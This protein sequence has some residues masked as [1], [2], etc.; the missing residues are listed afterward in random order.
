MA[1]L[2]G[3]KKPSNLGAGHK[4]TM[5]GKAN[6]VKNKNQSQAQF[7]EDGSPADQFQGDQHV[8][9]TD[10]S[11]TDPM[12]GVVMPKKPKNSGNS[13]GSPI[14]QIMKAVSQYAQKPKTK[15]PKVSGGPS[16]ANQKTPQK[17]GRVDTSDGSGF[18]GADQG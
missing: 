4:P 5:S 10:S 14:M 2:P 1:Q 7:N 9:N 16:K 6:P 8:P 11:A 15:A 18:D 3:N 13:V 17:K 12:D